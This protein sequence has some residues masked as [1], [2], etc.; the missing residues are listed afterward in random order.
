VSKIKISSIKKDSLVDVIGNVSFVI[1]TTGCNFRCPWC[2]NGDIVRGKG[3]WVSVENLIKEIEEA[4][5]YIDFVHFTGG[6]PCLQG[7]ALKIILD[8]VRDFGIKG[9]VNTNGYFPNVIRKL[10]LDHIAIDFKAPKE[11]YE[12]VIG[13]KLPDAFSRLIESL[14][15][16]FS[17]V[18]FTEIRTTY[19]PKLLQPEDVLSIATILREIFGEY[20]GRII[21]VLQQF[22]PSETLLSPE[23]KKVKS[24]SRS[25]LENLAKKVKNR[26][27]NK[28]EIYIR[29]KFGVKRI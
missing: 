6:E 16:A 18:P 17:E 29:G 13:R 8:R 5:K 12:A 20:E 19:V 15:I 7:D 26:L 24:P 1:W 22:V 27:P 25:F 4:K 28:F 21:Y 9:S 3:K 14:H 11:K 2:Q 10:T 23:F